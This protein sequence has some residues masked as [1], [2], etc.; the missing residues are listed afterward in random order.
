V[1]KA[2]AAALLLAAIVLPQRDFA[3]AAEPDLAYGEYQ[4]GN[5]LRAF[6]LAT[7]YVE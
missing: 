3:A 4:R 7:H 2:I 5:F 1:T 6:G